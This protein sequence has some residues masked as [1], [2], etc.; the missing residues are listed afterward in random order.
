MATDTNLK[1]SVPA[2]ARLMSADLAS[3]LDQFSDPD[4]LGEGKVNLIALNAIMEKLGARWPQRRDQIHGHVEKVLQ[5][6]LGSQGYHLRISETDFLIC[7]PE[8]GR[9]AGQ[10]AS[11][12]ALREVLTFFLG[13]ATQADSCVVQ[14]TRVTGDVIE[15]WQV[16]A[17]E[18]E[19]G[20]KAERQAS[21]GPP[22]GPAT[23][24]RWTPFIASDGRELR[25]TSD[26]EDVLALKSFSRI[27]SRIKGSVMGPGAEVLS[28][29]AI[30]TLSRADILRID[31]ATLARGMEALRAATPGAHP[32]SLIVPVSFTTLS[33]Q[34]GR[35]EFAKL[36]MEARG[37]VER[38]VICEI[39]A[40]EGVP[41][42]VML[43]VV[44]LIRPFCLFVVAHI[45]GRFPGA[46]T[47]SQLKRA[48]LQALSV[49]CPQCLGDAACSQWMKTTIEAA[50]R[51][52]RSI[53]LYGVPSPRH[54][55]L[56]G[57]F[58]ATHA[59]VK[60]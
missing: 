21:A 54:A 2:V 31:L 37:L 29:G 24:D 59:S 26:L 60:E 15:G 56:A 32:P 52:V 42:G 5:R 43:S 27:G 18:V 10:A 45:N 49:Q 30:S 1:Q 36:L 14:V 39:G 19:E 17:S 23:L 7:Q 22:A 53:L 4:L 35:A 33:S 9:F 44:S 50:R 57:Q 11:L 13:E 40:L 47:M 12:Q 41:E 51:V 28:A 55:V 48:G 6:R 16:L 3:A 25:V 38:G 8:L 34:R 46:T 58:G 20:E